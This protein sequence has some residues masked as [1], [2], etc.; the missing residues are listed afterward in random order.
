MWDGTGSTSADLIRMDQRTGDFSATGH[1][2]SSHMPDKNPKKNSAMLSGD[3]PLQAKAD[4]MDSRNKNRSIH[5]EG[6]VVM[7]QGANRLTANVADLDREKRTLAAN[8]NVVNYLWE[9]PKEEDKKKGATSVLTVVKAP[10]MA[11]TDSNRLAIYTGGVT[12][13]RPGMHVKSRQLSAYL[14][15]SDADS[16]LEKAFCDGAVEIVSTAKDHV[17]TGTAEHSEYFTDDQKVVLTGGQPKFVDMVNG[18]EKG[19]TQAPDSLTYYAND[20]RLL[21]SGA[22]NQPVQSR[23]HRGK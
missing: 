20:D 15:D 17:R 4:K 23:I 14:A 5:Y 21:S 2:N 10:T 18:K 11:Y 6:D 12:L 16:R 3:E 13:T 8:G 22:P 19:R 7:W 9:Q 1:I